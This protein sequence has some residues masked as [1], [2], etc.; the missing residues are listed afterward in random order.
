MAQGLQEQ[1][2]SE[3]VRAINAMHRAS[4]DDRGTVQSLSQELDTAWE[5]GMLLT[6]LFSGVALNLHTYT[7]TSDGICSKLSTRASFSAIPADLYSAIFT[8]LWVRLPDLEFHSHLALAPSTTS[9][10]L[11]NQ[12]TFFDHVILDNKRCLA[13]SRSSRGSA[14]SLVAVCTSASHIWVG[15][16]C[17]I[18]VINQPQIGAHRFG[19]MCWFA[20]FEHDLTG[21][22]WVAL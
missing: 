19:R 9:V 16:L 10:P 4:A 18:F 14:D 13:S 3:V 1:S 7:N 2:N 8:H 15:E 6:Y 5:D 20:P 17:D 22:I 12:A 11:T 21:T